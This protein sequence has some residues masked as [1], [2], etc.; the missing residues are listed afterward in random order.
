MSDIITSD[1]SSPSK[2]V[3][4]A[5]FLLNNNLLIYK[6][7]P[8]SQS[9]LVL[10]YANYCGH[11]R[12]FKPLWDQVCHSVSPTVKCVAFHGPDDKLLSAFFDV[13]SFPSIYILK[14]GKIQKFEG[15]RT[16]GNLLQFIKTSSS[17]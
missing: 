15:Q 7:A 9:V 5:D 17:Y 8:T 12:D 4:V 13:Q 1:S 11:C 3:S 6:G 14:N 2:K 10:A 16:Y